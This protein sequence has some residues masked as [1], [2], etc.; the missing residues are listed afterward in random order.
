MKMKAI[1]LVAASIL[2]TG[3]VLASPTKVHT[4]PFTD[5]LSVGTVFPTPTL[6]LLS[7]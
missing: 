7:T 3:T 2:V 5:N 1:A 6:P 4:S